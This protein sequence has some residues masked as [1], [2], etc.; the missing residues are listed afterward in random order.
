MPFSANIYKN[1]G[2]KLY[3]HVPAVTLLDLFDTEPVRV[4]DLIRHA[5]SGLLA[6]TRASPVIRAS[7]IIQLHLREHSV[8]P[9]GLTHRMLRRATIVFQSILITIESP[10]VHVFSPRLT[11]L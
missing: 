7:P 1:N 2:V 6:Y 4:T 11:V 8:G 10:P 9:E 5:D 3:D